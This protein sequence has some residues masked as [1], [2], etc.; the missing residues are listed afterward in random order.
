[1]D[2]RFTRGALLSLTLC[3]TACAATTTP[4]T[5]EAPQPRW[6]ETEEVGVRL[7]AWLGITDRQKPRV[8]QLAA[9]VKRT[10]EPVG[11]ATE[12]LLRAMAAGARRCRNDTAMIQLRADAVVR[13]GERAR[14]PILDAIDE[15]H[16]L[17]TPAQ[18]RTIVA[19]LLDEERDTD[20]ESREE[21]T[22]T[23]LGG[24]DLDLSWGQL[25]SM[26][27]RLRALQSEY[28]DRA[29]PW[30]DRYRS[31]VRAFAQPT[32]SA[33]DQALAD[34]PVV[35]LATSFLVDAYRQLIPLLEE[36][37]CRKLGDLADERLDALADE[38]AA[39]E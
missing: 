31:A 23:G 10:A 8:V 13:E 9:R 3:A 29:E 24:L 37:Q 33:H 25:A 26:L 32:F 28:E 27:V 11:D 18:R 22:E 21:R 38:R 6:I 14:R 19:R 15:L 1:M 17:L 5:A 7:P 39:A 35:E 2:R 30:L 20:R 4:V 16:A 34:V 12:S 36:E